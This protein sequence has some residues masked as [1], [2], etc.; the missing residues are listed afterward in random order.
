M[1]ALFL[2][3]ALLAGAFGAI[4]GGETTRGPIHTQDGSTPNQRATRRIKDR[5]A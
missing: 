2:T 3:L 1:Q 5:C 4:G